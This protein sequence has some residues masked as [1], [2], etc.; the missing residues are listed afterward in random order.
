MK[1]L[2]L[3]VDGVL[4]DGGLWFDPAGLTEPF[5]L[6]LEAPEVWVELDWSGDGGLER[7]EGGNS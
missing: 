2:V 4:T 7:I 6:R 1:L 5:R 3:D